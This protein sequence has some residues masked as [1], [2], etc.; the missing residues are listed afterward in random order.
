MENPKTSNS[1]VE[2]NVPVSKQTAG[3]VTGAVIGGVIADP[4]G[5]VI[6]GVAGAMMGNRAAE[7]KSRFR[8]GPL[9]LSKPRP[10]V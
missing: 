9:R 2:Q 10:K 1:K 5:A 3:G 6:G 7:G 4:V 8:Q